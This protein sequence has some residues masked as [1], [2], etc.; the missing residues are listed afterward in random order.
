MSHHVLVAEDEADIR[1]LLRL[2]LTGAGYEVETAPDGAAAWELAVARPPA[3][4]VTDLR[5][6]AMN[7]LELI[8][9]LRDA[10]ALR[11][12]PVILFTAFVSSDPRVAE[13]GAI[14]EV[15]VVTKGSIGEL[16][17]AVTRLLGAG[18][19]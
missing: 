18:A 2:A 15:E 12:V 16:R 19:A 6:P 9:A 17:Q 1:E 11:R 13:A 7:G 4:V 14:S 10:P 8:R 3:L 5:M